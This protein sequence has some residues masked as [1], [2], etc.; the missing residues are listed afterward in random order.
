MR[1]TIMRRA[2]RIMFRLLAY[3]SPNVPVPPQGIVL[4][5][6]NMPV[7]NG[8]EMLQEMRR[9]PALKGIPVIVVST[10]GSETRQTRLKNMAA[11]F[12]HKPFTPEQIVSV[13]NRLMGVEDAKES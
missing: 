3:R 10:E 11:E 4:A 1:D 8:E 9:D 2:S 7:M 13:M 12:V 5:D 6:V